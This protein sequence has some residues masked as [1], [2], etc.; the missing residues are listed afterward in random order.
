MVQLAKSAHG[1]LRAH[2]QPRLEAWLKYSKE[3]RD[4]TYKGDEDICIT[5]RLVQLADLVVGADAREQAAELVQVAWLTCERN[6][7]GRVQK[8]E[9]TRLL[10]PS[11]RCSP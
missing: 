1:E 7:T 8:D 4:D 3:E 9:T 2:R 6:A 11:R 10:G 5:R